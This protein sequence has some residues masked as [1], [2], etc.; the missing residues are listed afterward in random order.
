[1]L[2]SEDKNR[3]S[4]KT[5]DFLCHF[6]LVLELLPKRGVMCFLDVFFGFE[7]TDADQTIL[8]QCCTAKVIS[9][10]AICCTTSAASKSLNINTNLNYSSVVVH[11]V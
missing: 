1:M 8:C 6:Q 3:E 2:S 11:I 5:Q 4:S 10:G 7:N 9:A